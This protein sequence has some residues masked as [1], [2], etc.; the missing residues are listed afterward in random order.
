MVPERNGSLLTARRFLITLL[1]NVA[2][3]EN[4]GLKAVDDFFLVGK[5]GTDQVPDRDHAHQAVA[6]KNGKVPN[7]LGVITAM[8]SRTDCS[9]VAKIT[10]GV[11]ISPT[12]VSLEDLP[13]RMT[14]LA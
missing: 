1:G 6:V 9:G 5:D 10:L 11:M 2:V 4:V 12:V 8:Q 7:A 14:F 13:F 3:V